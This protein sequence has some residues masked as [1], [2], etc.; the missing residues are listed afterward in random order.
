MQFA[1][2]FEPADLLTTVTRRGEVTTDAEAAAVGARI[3]ELW[4]LAEARYQERERPRRYIGCSYY[5]VDSGQLSDRSAHLDEAEARE[6][7]TLAIQHSLYT[8]DPH[9]AHQRVLARLADLRSRRAA[10]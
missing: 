6:V 1:F 3:D 10:A 8:N 2:C 5:V 9:R 4:A 7:H